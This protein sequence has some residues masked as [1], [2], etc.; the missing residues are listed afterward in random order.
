MASEAS[1]R[2]K[3]TRIAF[4]KFFCTR[5]S[6]IGRSSTIGARKVTDGAANC[7]YTYQSASKL[8][9]RMDEPMRRNLPWIPGTLFA[10]IVG[11]SAS[12][13][14]DLSSVHA[15]ESRSDAL[16]ASDI[17]ICTGT[18]AESFGGRSFARFPVYLALDNTPN[19]GVSAAFLMKCGANT[20]ASLQAFGFPSDLD[21]ETLEHH[22][23]R[24][25]LVERL[26]GRSPVVLTCTESPFAQVFRQIDIK[27]SA[28]TPA[29]YAQLKPELVHDAT[30]LNGQAPP[31]IYALGCGNPLSVLWNKWDPALDIATI[32]RKQATPINGAVISE[33][34][35]QRKIVIPKIHCGADGLV[36]LPAQ[37]PADTRS[38]LLQASA[39]G[40]ELFKV[41][42]DFEGGDSAS[43]SY[44]VISNG[45]GYAIAGCGANIGSF[46]EAVGIPRD[47]EIE[48]LATDSPKFLDSKPNSQP[49]LKCDSPSTRVFETIN[50]PKPYKYFSLVDHRAS[51]VRFNCKTA[52]A[53]F[54]DAMPNPQTTKVPEESLPFIDGSAT[55][56]R[57]LDFQCAKKI[58]IN[59]SVTETRAIESILLTMEFAIDG[60]SY[61]DWD[62]LDKPNAKNSLV[63]N[64][65]GGKPDAAGVLQGNFLRLESSAGT[66]KR[67][68]ITK[69]DE[70]RIKSMKLKASFVIAGK[71]YEDSETLG[72]FSRD[73]ALTLN[74]KGGKFDG[75][76][77]SGPYLSQ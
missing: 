74:G 76:K 15:L 47:Q 68:V 20:Q 14:V 70:R 24:E 75:K 67:I 6:I 35:E 56:R 77:W 66:G 30:D 21:I 26:D 51:L 73:I 44:Y 62:Y 43:K 72:E 36:T 63:L 46:K 5:P 65:S 48:E 3:F 42:Y 8:N 2:E 19:R 53:F 40:A 27:N 22:E 17:V 31:A 57:L 49:V 59:I 12:D 1:A 58:A 28:S 38:E 64:G 37:P 71:T 33:W 54:L 7:P 61:S 52:E 25:S 29:Y 45:L 41:K 10:T 4:P 32:L 9:Q 13:S 11:C 18:C 69:T 34:V 23:T 50:R 16:S 55:P 60:K 39:G